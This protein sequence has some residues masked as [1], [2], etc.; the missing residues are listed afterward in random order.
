M[1]VALPTHQ[2]ARNLHKIVRAM[3][4]SADEMGRT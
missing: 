3:L 2:L 1:N 4:H